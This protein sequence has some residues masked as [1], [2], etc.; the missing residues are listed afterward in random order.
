MY[1]HLWRQLRSSNQQKF[2]AFLKKKTY[3]TEYK[4][5]SIK[6]QYIR[7]VQNPKKYNFLMNIER[8]DKHSQNE[9]YDYE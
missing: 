8:T 6:Y 7:L 9:N 2:F 1:A 5:V 4:Q 3:C